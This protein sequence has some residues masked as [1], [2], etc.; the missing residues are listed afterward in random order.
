MSTRKELLTELKNKVAEIVAPIPVE[1]WP[2]EQAV[3]N[4]SLRWPIVYVAYDG[5]A[6]DRDME[7][8]GSPQHALWERIFF[9]SVFVATRDGVD[10]GY[11]QALDLLETL[12][13]ALTGFV[14]SVVRAEW[15]MSAAESLIHAEQRQWLY[16]QPWQIKSIKER[17]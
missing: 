9:F 1:I 12:E 2:G 10:A 5:L 3:F 8:G 14:S 16:Q 13:E 4:D 7:L 15:S 11:E 17:I 6:A